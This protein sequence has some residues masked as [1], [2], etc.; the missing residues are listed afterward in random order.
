MKRLIVNADDFGLTDGVNQAIIDAHHLDL[1]SSTT[2]LANGEAFAAA[3]A[4]RARPR[5]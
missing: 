4:C 2:L 5:V 3:V 1:L